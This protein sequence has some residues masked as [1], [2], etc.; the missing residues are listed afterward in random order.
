MQYWIF[1][2]YSLMIVKFIGR[3]VKD[4]QF[5]FF[6]IRFFLIYCQHL[7]FW[8]DLW[9]IFT[10]AEWYVFSF[11]LTILIMQ[12][13]VPYMTYGRYTGSC[14]LFMIEIYIWYFFFIGQSFSCVRIEI[15]IFMAKFS[16]VLNGKNDQAIKNTR[17]LLRNWIIWIMFSYPF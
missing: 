13:V 12:Y 3:S 2:F 1:F 6:F 4:C 7:K 9:S 5:S 16:M 17:I 14:Q 11:Y 15:G 10:L 8:T